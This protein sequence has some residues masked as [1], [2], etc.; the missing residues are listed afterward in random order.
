MVLYEFGVDAYA[1]FAENPIA[2]DAPAHRPAM[3]RA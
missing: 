2:V 3:E 1:G